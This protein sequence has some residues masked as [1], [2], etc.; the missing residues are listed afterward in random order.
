I[1]KDKAEQ[2][3]LRGFVAGGINSYQTNSSNEVLVQPSAALGIR[4]VGRGAGNVSYTSDNF[5]STPY[6]TGNRRGAIQLMQRVNK[7]WGKTNYGGGFTYSRYNPTYF[8]PRFTS[9][10]NSLLKA[11]MN[12][13]RSLSSFVS[14]NIQPSYNTEE[15]SYGMMNDRIQLSTQS[16]QLMSSANIRSKNYKHSMYTSLETGLIAIKGYTDRDFILRGNL[17]YHY[18]S[19]GLSAMYQHGAFRVFEV[20]NDHLFDQSFGSRLMFSANYGGAIFR[21]KLTWNGNIASNISSAYGN[22]YSTNLSTAYRVLKNTL[23]TGTFQYNYTEGF[24]GYQYDFTNVR[25]GIRQNMRSQNLDRSAVKT[26][27]LLVFCYYD[28]NNNNIFDQ[29]DEIAKGYNFLIGG[30]NFVTD[31]KG[32]AEFKKVPYGER[33]LFFPTFNGYQGLSQ[34][35]D[36]RGKSLSVTI[37]LQRVGTVRG[38]LLIRYDTKLS[39]DANLSLDVYTVVARDRDNN[40]FEARTDQH[41]GYLLSLPQGEYTVFIKESTFPENIFSE[42]NVRTV[43]VKIGENQKLEP[44]VLQV[45]NRAVEIKRFGN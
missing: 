43:K 44:F 12:F 30:I 39:L 31:Q 33:I 19:L 9:Y 21:R 2:I 5:Y 4:L 7:M 17:S 23:L 40:V 35:L 11:D 36:I 3:Q 18:G 28:N 32:R 20:L 1:G 38:G 22:T 29:G 8:N 24:S 16:W 26:G 41:G 34:V 25:L 14:V 42:D 45:R 13:Y 27:N 10:D 6:Y 15:A 37:P